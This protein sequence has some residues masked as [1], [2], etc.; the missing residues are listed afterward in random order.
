MVGPTGNQELNETGQT[1]FW[2]CITPLTTTS[3]RLPPRGAS[4]NSKSEKIYSDKPTNLINKYKQCA[5]ARE[6]VVQFE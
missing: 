4:I 2:R 5:P 3:T 6:N 1:L